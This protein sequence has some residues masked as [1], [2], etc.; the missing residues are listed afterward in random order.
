M[1]PL[2]LTAGA[3]ATLVLTKALEKTGEK[4]GEKAIEQ[5]GKLMQLL[6]HKSPETASAIELVAQRPELAEQQPLDYGEAVLVEK[7]ETAAEV[8]PEIKAAIEDL[9][10]KVEAATQKS[11]QLAEVVK[12]VIENWQGINIKGGNNTIN[13]PNLTFGSK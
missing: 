7:V 6:K 9:A 5:G 3:I 10:V 8:H 11:P 4:L 1:E 12:T 13:N 2:S